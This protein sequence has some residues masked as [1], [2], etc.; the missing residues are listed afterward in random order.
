MSSRTRQPVSLH[1]TAVLYTGGTIAQL[2]KLFLSF[3]WTEMP[4]AI[5]WAIVVL[6]SIGAAGLVAFRHLIE[7]R[8]LWEQVVH[9]IIV[10]HLVSSVFLHIWTIARGDHE[11][12]AA[13]PHE[14][15]YFAALYFG[16]FA[17]RSWTVRLRERELRNAV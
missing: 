12:Y 15:S 17:W 5:D 9:W 10:L 3:R 14:Y 7:F 2:L 16:F 11:F 1:A 6:G 4:F 8:G 13:F